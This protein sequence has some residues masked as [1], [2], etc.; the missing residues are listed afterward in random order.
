M[1]VTGKP[2]PPDAAGLRLCRIFPGDDLRLCETVLFT[3]GRPAVDTIL[4]RAAISGGRVEIEPKGP[5]PDYFA[6]VMNKNC[7]MVGHVALDR[8]SFNALKNHWMRCKYEP[9][10]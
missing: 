8:L 10:E 4:R 6:D 7:D 1:S 9:A 3:R 2:L 5:L